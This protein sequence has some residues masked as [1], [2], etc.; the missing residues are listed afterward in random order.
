[1]ASTLGTAPPKRKR[2]AVTCASPSTPGRGGSSQ[3][4][5]APAVNKVKLHISYIFRPADKHVTIKFHYEGELYKFVPKADSEELAEVFKA[6]QIE[7]LIKYHGREMYQAGGTPG[8]KALNPDFAY[9]PGYGNHKT[10]HEETMPA[11]R[12]VHATL[13]RLRKHASEHIAAYHFLASPDKLG[14][15]MRT[16]ENEQAFVDYI[17]SV[18]EPLD[19]EEE[20]AAADPTWRAQV[21]QRLARIEKK[22]K[23]PSLDEATA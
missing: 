10:E 19:E 3:D 11:G 12:C 18:P 2:A 1:M 9:Y 7:G 14:D 4:P 23:L 15:E 6:M 5:A 13:A 21:E 22:L 16:Y 17:D 20:A 8:Q